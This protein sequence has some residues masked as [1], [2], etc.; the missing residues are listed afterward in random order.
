MRI[1]IGILFIILAI[2]FKHIYEISLNVI[3]EIPQN[4]G[5]E[6]VDRIYK[7]WNKK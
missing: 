7:A 5:H 6:V 3:Q 1:G 4:N 2:S